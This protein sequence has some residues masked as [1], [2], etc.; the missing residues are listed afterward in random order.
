MIAAIK[1]ILIVFMLIGVAFALYAAWEI[2]QTMGCVNISTGIGTATFVGYY[3]EY[4]ETTSIREMPGSGMLSTTT[5]LS[6]LSLPEFKYIAPDGRERIVREEKAHIWELYKPGEKVDILLFEYFE[7]RLAGYY[8]L[9]NRDLLI[10]IM[11]LGFIL[12][13]FLFLKF[14]LP[15]LAASERSMEQIARAEDYIGK[16]LEE[17]IGPLTIRSYLIGCGFFIAFMLWFGLGAL[18]EPYLPEFRFGSGGR[19]LSAMEQKRFD[20]AKTILAGKPNVNKANKYD[21]TPLILALEAGRFDLGRLLI[22]A[23]A[24]VNVKS[25]MFKTPIRVATQAGDLDMVRLLLSKGASADV[26][27]DETPPF[28]YALAK[29]RYDIARALVEGGADLK[30]V[31]QE[32]D[33]TYTLGD[34]AV[35]A[36]QQD[37]ADSIRSR[38]GRFLK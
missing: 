28:V 30:R 5:G 21:Q 27:A 37:L 16:V 31:Y 18:I 24:D 1:I 20:E 17:R 12:V 14:A 23:G 15:S 19:L 32:G 2:L 10:L 33:F 13:P 8:A 22:D 36:K 9:Y 34:M 26:P 11:G 38:G 6:I 29:K 3:R 4:Y 7:P 35:L 25:K